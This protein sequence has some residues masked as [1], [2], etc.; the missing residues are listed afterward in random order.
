M[1][2]TSTAHQRAVLTKALSNTVYL[3]IKYA[4]SIL[5]SEELKTSNAHNASAALGYIRMLNGKFYIYTKDVDFSREAYADGSVVE[6]AGL[7]W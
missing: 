7:K 3:P 6:V 5:T 4:F 2:D 1:N